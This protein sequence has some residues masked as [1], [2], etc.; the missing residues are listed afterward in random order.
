M[1]HSA[2]NLGASTREHKL[3]TVEV[4]ADREVAAW[5]GPTGEPTLTSAAR[6]GRSCPTDAAAPGEWKILALGHNNI[7]RREPC[8]KPVP[9]SGATSPHRTHPQQ[10]G[11]A[12]AGHSSRR[13]QRQHD[14]IGRQGSDGGGRTEKKIPSSSSHQ[15][16]LG[17][18]TSI[19]MEMVRKQ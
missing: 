16:Q 12:C 4:V 11:R 14:P 13:N 15:K 18:P 3:T 9:A 1:A 6:S 17:T 8:R 7:S 10:G 19:Y 5:S 2:Q